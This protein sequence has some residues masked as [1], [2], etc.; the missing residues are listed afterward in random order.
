MSKRSTIRKRSVAAR[1]RIGRLLRRLFRLLRWRRCLA[2]RLVSVQFER[3]RSEARA[4]ACLTGA[5][6][7]L[8]CC[9]IQRVANPALPTKLKERRETSE[10][11]AFSLL[12]CDF[13]CETERKRIQNLATGRMSKQCSRG[14][15]NSDNQ[16]RTKLLPDPK[17]ELL[18][19][20]G[21]AFAAYFGGMSRVLAR[22]QTSTPCAT[23]FPHYEPPLTLRKGPP[24]NAASCGRDWPVRRNFG[25]TSQKSASAMRSSVPPARAHDRPVRTPSA[26]RTI[27]LTPPA[28]NRPGLRSTCHYIRWHARRASSAEK[29]VSTIFSSSS[30]QFLPPSD[31]CCLSTVQEEVFFRSATACEP[32]VVGS[33]RPGHPIL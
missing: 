2:V 26:R 30:I 12:G 14:R 23:C 32:Q 15:T 3:A 22:R 13:S 21:S 18:L 25:S 11:V 16:G 31:R 1:L 33:F 19:P 27:N 9:A 6:R 4:Q 20:A 10:G 7:H 24:L 8:A 29:G 17:Y 28:R 5:F